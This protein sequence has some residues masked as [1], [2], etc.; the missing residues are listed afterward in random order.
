MFNRAQ[1]GDL[2]ITDPYLGMSHAR[3][4]QERQ[5]RELSDNLEPLH[6]TGKGQA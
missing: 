3:K 6:E 1:I 2:Q 5:A 4:G